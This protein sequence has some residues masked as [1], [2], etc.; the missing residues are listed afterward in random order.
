MLFRPGF[1]DQDSYFWGPSLHSEDYSGL[2]PS[3]SWKEETWLFL[4]KFSNIF[5]SYGWHRPH[6]MAEQKHNL[7]SQQQILHISLSSCSLL[8]IKTNR[9][10]DLGQYPA[11]NWK[12]TSW[13]GLDTRKEW[14]GS[15]HNYH[16]STQRLTSVLQNDWPHAHRITCRPTAWGQFSL[17][18]IKRTHRSFVW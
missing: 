18:A 3:F 11:P 7:A 8:C 17:I 16:W 12:L 14:V 13:P 1:L 15:G 10:S 9:W 5:C 6:S 2:W 4:W